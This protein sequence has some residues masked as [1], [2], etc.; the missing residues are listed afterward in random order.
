MSKHLAPFVG[1]SAEFIEYLRHVIGDTG[2]MVFVRPMA[3]G[4]AGATVSLVNLPPGTASGRDRGTDDAEAWNNRMTFSI[5]L[6]PNGKAK[7]EML[8]S[9]LPRSYKLRAKTAATAAVAQ[10]L[11]DFLHHVT[12]EVPPHYTHTVV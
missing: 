11:A 9:S 7:V 10:Y 8:M 6:L 3:L 2:R 4:G 1:G 5:N 12:D